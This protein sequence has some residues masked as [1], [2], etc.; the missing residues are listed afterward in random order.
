MIVAT[1]TVIT[2]CCP[3]CGKMEYNAVSLFTFSRRN[4]IRL[5]CGCGAVLGKLRSSDRK[6]FYLEFVC[7]MC[8]ETHM[9]TFSR[10]LLWT[11]A[12]TPIFCLDTDLEAGFAGKKESIQTAMREMEQSIEEM[13]LELGY[14]EYF[15]NPDV[16]YNILERLYNIAEKGYLT[17]QCGSTDIEMEIFPDRVELQ[18]ESCTSVDNIP[19]AMPQDESRV[20]RMDKLLL[21]PRGI[22]AS[23][24]IQLFSH[25]KRHGK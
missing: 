10:N 22:T 3:E 14:D 15:E 21:T 18:C 8:T 13:A 11:G 1:T 20:E 4:S 5:K 19:A 12:A 24:T 6:T 23:N 9:Y 2:L 17:C 7:G 25:G 16:M